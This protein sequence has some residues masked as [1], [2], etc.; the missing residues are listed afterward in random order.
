LQKTPREREVD[1]GNGAEIIGGKE[2]KRF[3][4]GGRVTT[5]DWGGF[6]CKARGKEDA[7][8]VPAGNAPKEKGGSI[9][10]REGKGWL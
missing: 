2:R 7:V 1:F 6:K 4:Q 3:C 10:L 8:V 5:I 9:A